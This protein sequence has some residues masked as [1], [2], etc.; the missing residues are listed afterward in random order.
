MGLYLCIM[1]SE[2]NEVDGLEIGSYEYFGLFRDSVKI[3]IEKGDWGSVCPIMMWHKDCDGE[4]T[5]E[6]CKELIMELKVI[7]EVFLKL[8][9]DQDV[10]NHKEN[11]FKLFGIIAENLY[12]C[13]LDVDG[14][15]IIE[16]LDDLCKTAIK[17]NLSI[18]F[19]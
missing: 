7:K 3:N 19:Q 1:N 2:E 12:D 17:E 6:E 5:P 4:W 13:F 14:E 18:L 11:L 15:N 8:P 9:V 10:I 16:R